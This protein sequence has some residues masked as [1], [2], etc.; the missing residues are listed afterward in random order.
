MPSSFWSPL[1]FL[2]A[3]FMVSLFAFHPQNLAA[4]IHV[5]SP[6]DLQQAT[7]SASRQRQANVARLNDFLSSPVAQ[8]ALQD[9]H[10]DSAQV[11]TA[12]ANLSDQDL[13][14]LAARAEKAQKDFAAGS[15]TDHM[16]LLMVI[17]IVVVVLIIVAVKV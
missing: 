16:L 1:R 14:Q 5:V 6:G 13:A 9:A 8:K 4:Q 12:V 10:L 11:K 2:I 7:V 17:A 3:C 15:I